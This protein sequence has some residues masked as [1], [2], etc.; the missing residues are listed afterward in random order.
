[1]VVEQFVVGFV[2]GTHGLT[3]EVKIESSSGCYTHIADLKEVTLRFGDRNQVYSIEYTK[4]VCETLYM[5]FAGID[6]P[7]Q[8]AKIRGWELVVP[9][10]LAQPL[11][12]NEWYVED[13]KQCNLVFDI[14]KTSQNGIAADT[15]PAFKLV[16]K[17]TDVLEGGADDLLEIELSE[18]FDLLDDSVK[19]TESGKLRKVLV[20]LSNRF[21]GN[22]DMMNM[23]V[24]LMHLWILE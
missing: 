12:K 13:L 21:I 9:R 16:G 24:E 5:K 2:R 10:E 20:P 18:N 3:G 17:I 11:Q 19:Y 15:A 8:A 7:E 22:I 14:S 1:M 4:P 23:T 6:T